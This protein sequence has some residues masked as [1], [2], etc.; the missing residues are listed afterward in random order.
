MLY[1]LF[2]YLEEMY[3]FTGASLFGFL[4]FRAA[5]AIIL[6]L[7]ISTVFGKYII[8]FLHKKQLW[9][10]FGVTIQKLRFPRPR[11]RQGNGNFGCLVGLSVPKNGN[12][13]CLAWFSTTTP[14]L[15]MSP[16]VFEAHDF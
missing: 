11:G 1:Y 12:I 2:K 4:T 15:S 5:V 16:T 13:G 3:Q 10:E 6:S 9:L 14:K 8:S 7:F